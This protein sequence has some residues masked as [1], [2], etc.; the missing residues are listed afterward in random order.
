MYY[1]ARYD[2]PDTGRF[3]QPDPL[4]RKKQEVRRMK[5][6]GKTALKRFFS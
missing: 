5:N 2:A 6:W 1:R 3:L 4:G